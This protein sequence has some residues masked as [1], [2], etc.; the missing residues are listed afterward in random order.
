MATEILIGLVAAIVIGIGAQWLARKI[1]VPAILLLLA[2]G[3]LAGPVTG[4][5]VPEQIFGEALLPAVSLAVG[6][7]LFEGGLSLRIR[8]LRG[9]G[10]PV[11][12]LST[13]GVILTFTLTALAAAVLLP[14]PRPAAIVVGAI[15]VVSGP[16]VV[17]PLLAYAKPESRVAELLRWEGIVIDP[18]GATLSVAVLNA[19]VRHQEPA[20]G[21]LA[22]AATGVG[23]GLLGAAIYVLVVRRRWV[24]FDLEVPLAL[25]LVVAAF[26]VAEHRL[27]EAGLFATTTLGIALANQ[28]LVRLDHLEQFYRATSVVVLG[29]LFALLGALVDLPQLRTVWLPTLLLVICLVLVIRPLVALVCTAGAGLSLRQRAFV[30]ILAPR[31]IVAAATAS[32]FDLKLQA[33]GRDPGALDAV[34][35]LVIVGTCVFYGSVARLGA[36]VLRV[37]RPPSRAIALFGSAPWLQALAGELR[38][39]GAQVFVVAPGAA[40]PAQADP[41]EG[42]YTG[43]LSELGEGHALNDVDQVVLASQDSDQNLLGAL[44]YNPRLGPERVLVLVP[45]DPLPPGSEAAK[46]ATWHPRAFG[47]AFTHAQLATAFDGG[48]RFVSMRVP[49]DRRLDARTPV[50]AH[51]LDGGRVDLTVRPGTLAPGDLVVALAPPA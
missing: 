37:A 19:L 33:V 2:A 39:L 23:V 43:A 47:G 18:I 35:F 42:R 6:L 16:T 1:E 13:V 8:E 3:V 20:V 50:L 38:R 31:G 25:L 17:G 41:D 22:T 46:L 30:G 49:A 26:A 34:V 27:D 4:L 7:L 11:V 32:L 48:H 51:V 9:L 14:L 10:R 12:L 29:T 44:R 24:P 40:K 21:L 36:R 15:L 45:S 5:I 28:R